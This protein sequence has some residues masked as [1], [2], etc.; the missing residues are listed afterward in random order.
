MNFHY[1]QISSKQ[2]LLPLHFHGLWWK[3]DFAQL[4]RKCHIYIC[5]QCVLQKIAYPCQGNQWKNLWY[6]IYCYM[7]ITLCS[8]E[9]VRGYEEGTTP[10][11][12]VLCNRYIK[13][14]ALFKHAIHTLGKSADQRINYLKNTLMSDLLWMNTTT[15]TISLMDHPRG[16]YDNT[17]KIMTTHKDIFSLVKI[18]DFIK[19]KVEML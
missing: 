17:G 1:Y 14:G 12:D 19:I 7:S 2:F 18:R 6:D 5:D 15:N 11:P 10:N 4:R 8:S 9:M 13:F 16:S 3:S